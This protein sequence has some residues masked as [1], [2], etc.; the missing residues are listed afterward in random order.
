[1][2]ATR[3]RDEMADSNSMLVGSGELVLGTF[4]G[5]DIEVSILSW[6]EVRLRLRLKDRFLDVDFHAAA[7]QIFSVMSGQ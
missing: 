5:E 1:M 2:R 6:R 7:P 4:K 3:I